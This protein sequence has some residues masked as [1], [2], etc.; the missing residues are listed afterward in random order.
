[1]LR[2]AR[3]LFELDPDERRFLVAAWLLAPWA[4]ITVRR[5]TLR[6]VLDRLARRKRQ[7]RVNR[8]A[9]DVERGEWLVRAAFRRAPADARCLPESIVQYL[10]HLRWGPAP[11]LVIGIVGDRRTRTIED[12]AHAWVEAEDGPRREPRFV[13]ILELTATHG[14]APAGTAA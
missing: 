5:G 1:V 7:H 13:P 11:R 3:T 6:N 9:I 10:L 4:S 12:F 14:V 8:R 2:H